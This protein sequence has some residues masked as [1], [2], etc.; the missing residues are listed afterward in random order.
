M[1]DALVLNSAR[2]VRGSSSSAL[3]RSSLL[4]LLCSRSWP[5]TQSP[6][7]P[8]PRKRRWLR[9]RL[10]LRCVHQATDVSSAGRPH[11]P[12]RLRLMPRTTPKRSL[13][14]HTHVVVEHHAAMGVPVGFSPAVPQIMVERR[15]VGKRLKPEGALPHAIGSKAEACVRL[16]PPPSSTNGHVD[17]QAG[18]ALASSSSCSGRAY[19]CPASSTSARSRCMRR[20]VRLSGPRW[21]RLSPPH[22]HG[23]RRPLLA[24]ASRY[25]APYAIIAPSLQVYVTPAVIT[26]PHAAAMTAGGRT[27]EDA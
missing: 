27:A 13:Q 20:S 1:D 7:L 12:A 11:R 18:C 3:L 2:A 17:V 16:A 24:C 21:P 9:R 19:A 5:P 10:C 4:S 26:A 8:R 15:I 22:A 14:H 23:G 6:Q 25:C